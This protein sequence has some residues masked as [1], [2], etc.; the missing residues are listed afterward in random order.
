MKQSIRVIA[1]VTAA[2]AICACDEGLKTIAGPTP[3]LG[4][5]FSSI[6]TEIFETTD[7]SGRSLC[8]GCHTN[9]GRTPLG[10]LNLLRDVAYDQLVNVPS[11]QRPGILR[12]APNN[13]EGSYLIHKLEQSGPPAIGGLRMPRNG[14]PYLTSGQLLIVRRWIETGAPRN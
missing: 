12:V 5:T 14:P 1:F 6:Q 4:P 2:A 13:P 7:S 8:T 3:N 9:V 11:V 10:G